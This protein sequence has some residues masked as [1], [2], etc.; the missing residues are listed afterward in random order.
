MHSMTQNRKAYLESRILDLS[1]RA[2]L[3]VSEVE[4]LYNA[5]E[6]IDTWHKHNGI[7]QRQTGEATDTQQRNQKDVR[8]R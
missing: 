3:T 6:E 4:E 1:G 5:Q 7:S 2:S 8:P